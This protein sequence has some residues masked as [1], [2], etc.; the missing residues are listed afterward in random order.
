MKKNILYIATLY[1]DNLKFKPSIIVN[2]G[3]GIHDYWLLGKLFIIET[4][5]DRKHISSIFKYF[6]RYVNSEA[7]KH[8]RK[9]GSVHYL[10][11]GFCEY[12]EL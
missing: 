12:S 10:A 2:S 3:N 9:I 7:E 11:K 6:R 5:N 4:E 1:D 8:G